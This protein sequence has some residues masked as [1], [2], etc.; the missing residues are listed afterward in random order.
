MIKLAIETYPDDLRV[1]V[2]ATGGLSHFIGEPG[3]GQID[4]RFDRTCINCSRL[5]FDLH[6]PRIGRLMDAPRYARASS[7]FLPDRY[8]AALH[9][10]RRDQPA[11][12]TRSLSWQDGV[13]HPR[14]QSAL[15]HRHLR[16]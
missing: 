11:W 15:D 3:M 12:R 7:R 8:T 14:D 9:G 2:L 10:R 1:A 13:P 5:V 4:E 6:T 16:L